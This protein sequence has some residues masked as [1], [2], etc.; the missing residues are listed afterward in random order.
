MSPPVNPVI[1]DERL[2]AAVDV[3]V[4]GG[5]IIDCLSA[6]HLALKRLSVAVIEKAISP[7]NNRAANGGG[8][9]K[10]AATAGNYR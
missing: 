7:A 10:A 9:G 8:A 3:V 5:G 2:P 6:Y 1:S 4:V